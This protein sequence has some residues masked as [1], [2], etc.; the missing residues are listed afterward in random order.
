MKR[1]DKQQ[2]ERHLAIL[3]RMREY[4]KK[5]RNEQE[6]VNG[7]LEAEYFALDWVLREISEDGKSNPTQDS[8]SLK[9]N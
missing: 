5:K 7:F 9:R 6:V 3:C 2:R 8:L 4:R 1:S